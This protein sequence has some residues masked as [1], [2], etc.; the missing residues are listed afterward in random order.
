[1]HTRGRTFAGRGGAGA[2][3]RVHAHEREGGGGGG[4]PSGVMSTSLATR[5]VNMCKHIRSIATS[6]RRDVGAHMRHAHVA[7]VRVCAGRNST[8]YMRGPGGHATVQGCDYIWSQH[9]RWHIPS[10][11]ALRSRRPD[12][13]QLRPEPVCAVAG[14]R[15]MPS[16]ARCE[17]GRSCRICRIQSQCGDVAI[18][19]SNAPETCTQRASMPVCRRNYACTSYL[20]GRSTHLAGPFF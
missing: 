4:P 7:T 11:R 5:Y 17:N 8:I 20:D 2:H 13:Q 19:T 1:M 18:T 15:R 3:M 9:T 6:Y 12:A 14:P 16:P 10:V